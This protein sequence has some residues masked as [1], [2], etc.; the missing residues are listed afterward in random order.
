MSINYQQILL[1]ILIVLIYVGIRFMA[2]RLFHGRKRVVGWQVLTTFLF[3]ALSFW[4]FGWYWFAYPVAVWM[5]LALVLIIVQVIHNH[6]FLYRHY[7]PVFW[8]YSTFIAVVSFVLSLFAGA[9]PLI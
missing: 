4:N 3:F 5:I 7:W 2:S 8:H 9:L 1:Q 6:E